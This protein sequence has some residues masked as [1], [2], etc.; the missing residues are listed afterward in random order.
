VIGAPGIIDPEIR[1]IS[2]A[3]EGG[4]GGLNEVIGLLDEVLEA[5]RRMRKGDEFVLHEK[6][7][8]NEQLAAERQKKGID[9]GENSSGWNGG[10]FTAERSRG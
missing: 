2:L 7:P 1:L 8:G 6:T 4:L 3:G 10:G 5:G 9:T